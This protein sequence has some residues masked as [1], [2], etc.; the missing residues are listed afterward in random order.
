MRGH[1]IVAD[2][3]GYTRFLTESELEHAHG[4]IGEL[5][6][7]ILE[8]IQA[9]LTVSRIE[10]DAVFLY[11]VMP[12]G[13]SGPV[14]LESVEQLYIGFAKAMETMVMNTTCTCNACANIASLGLKIVM[15]CGE[16]QKTVVAGI[17]TLTGAEVIVV[18]RL[19]KNHIREDTG[20]DDYLYLTQ[21][22]VDDLGIEHIVAGWTPHTETYEHLGTIE[23]YVSSLPD[24]WQF[25]R[26]QNED[27]V[28]QRDAWRTVDAYSKAPPVVVWD[29]MVDPAKRNRWMHADTH[30]VFNDRGG[31]VAPGMEYHCVHGDNE[32]L[33]FTVLDNRPVEYLTLRFPVDE[34]FFLRYT[35]YLT[36]SGNGTHVVTHFAVPVDPQTGEHAPPEVLEAVD[37]RL[38]GMWPTVQASLVEM[39]NAAA[40]VEL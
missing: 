1:L 20:V 36:A 32:L 15:H 25:V 5:L 13:M 24:V 27:R 10:G 22:C 31:R 40:L 4:I 2:I 9:P 30:T 35:E 6:N 3:S 11:G 16:F 14:V 12:E 18:H 7:A 19:L 34:R 21:A 8:T 39:A 26:S 23:G 37:T 17:E 38:I 29:H 33:V 28:V